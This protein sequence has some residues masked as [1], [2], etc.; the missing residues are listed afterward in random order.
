M[1]KGTAAPS[2][3]MNYLSSDQSRIAVQYSCSHY[4]FSLLH[5]ATRRTLNRKHQALH[6]EP[7]PASASRLDNAFGRRRQTRLQYRQQARFA[8][9]TKDKLAMVPYSK[10]LLFYEPAYLAAAVNKSHICPSIIIRHLGTSNTHSVLPVFITRSNEQRRVRL[11]FLLPCSRP[12][13]LNTQE[14]TDNNNHR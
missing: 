8:A 5:G 2:A 3:V 13:N 12:I 9:R 14:T 11:S 4:G 10:H 6:E 7:P 1:N